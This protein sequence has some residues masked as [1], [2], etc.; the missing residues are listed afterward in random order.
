MKNEI[1]RRLAVSSSVWLGGGRCVHEKRGAKA[2]EEKMRRRCMP[3]IEPELSPEREE[4]LVARRARGRG[5]GAVEAKP[6]PPALDRCQ[7][8]EGWSKPKTE[9][10][11]DM[12]R[13]LSGEL[14]KCSVC[15]RTRKTT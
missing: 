2:S 14:G 4:K 1:V 15:M 13:D 6:R 8:S 9:Q 11:G 10:T 3:S 12:R 5:S 7:K